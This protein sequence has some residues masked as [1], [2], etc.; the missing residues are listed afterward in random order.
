MKSKKASQEVVC[1]TGPK[2]GKFAIQK[3]RVK[4]RGQRTAQWEGKTEC[5]MT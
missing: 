4:D 5:L 1:A 3:M 2:Q